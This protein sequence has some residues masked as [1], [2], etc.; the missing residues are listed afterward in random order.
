[1]AEELL[2][3]PREGEPGKQEANAGE[4]TEPM[5]SPE[6]EGIRLNSL[7]KLLL[8]CISPHLDTTEVAA[9]AAGCH[10]NENVAEGS[11]FELFF[12]PGGSLLS[13]LHAAEPSSVSSEPPTGLFPE[14]RDIF[15]VS[16]SLTGLV[17]RYSRGHCHP[18]KVEVPKELK[19]KSE[20]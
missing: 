19:D 8:A 13:S 11:T 16:N 4:P 15:V 10:E 18:T 12:L 9:A 20:F 7:P 17:V 1:M 2:Q 5:P 3:P 6:R 14:E